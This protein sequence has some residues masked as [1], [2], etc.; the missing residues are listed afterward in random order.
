[1]LKAK[2]ASESNGETAA[3]SD[4]PTWWRNPYCWLVLAGPIVVVFAGLATVSIAMVNAEVNAAVNAH[5]TCIFAMPGRVQS[6]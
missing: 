2:P 6:T 3:W 5:A 1:M 4:S